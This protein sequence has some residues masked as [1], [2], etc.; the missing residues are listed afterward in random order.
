MHINRLPHF[1][2]AIVAVLGML[3]VGE[4][5]QGARKAN[6][7]DGKAMLGEKAKTNGQHALDKKGDYSASVDVKDGKIAAF[8]VKHAKKGDV[9]VTKYKSN[10]KMALN[11]VSIF[12]AYAQEYVGTTYIGYSYV[13]DFG[14]EEIYW[15]PYDM[16]LD[17]SGAIEYIP[18]TGD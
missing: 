13:D 8:H 9:Q 6:H 11:R 4:M 15:F 5:A 3:A 14:N 12:A 17:P 2:V 1:L 10:K 18:A 7:H 16:I